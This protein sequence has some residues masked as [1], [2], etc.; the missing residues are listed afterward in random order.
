[1]GLLVNNRVVKIVGRGIQI[2]VFVFSIFFLPYPSFSGI[3]QFFYDRNDFTAKE[4]PGS[5]FYAPRYSAIVRSAVSAKERYGYYTTNELR[6]CQQYLPINEPPLS[7]YCRLTG[8][9]AGE[10]CINYKSKIYCIGGI[11]H[12]GFSSNILEY[13]FSKKSLT[14]KTLSCSKD[15]EPTERKIADTSCVLFSDK[16]YCFGGVYILG[17]E[18]RYYDEIIEYSP[19]D[20][21][22]LVKNSK[23]P[24]Q[25]AGLSCSS[26]DNGKI[27]CIGGNFYEIE[28]MSE[29]L[30]YDPFSDNISVKGAKLPSGRDFASCVPLSG[31]IYCIG[32]RGKD[33]Y[34]SDIL[35]YDYRSDSISKKGDYPYKVWGH[36]CSVQNNKILCFGGFSSV[37]CDFSKDKILCKRS[38]EENLSPVVEF[39]IYSTS[40][41]AVTSYVVEYPPIKQKKSNILPRVKLSCTPYESDIFCFGG[42]I[43]YRDGNL[44][45][46]IFI[47]SANT[48]TYTPKYSH[49]LLPANRVGASCVYYNGGVYCFGGYSST[50]AFFGEL[51]EFTSEVLRYDIITGEISTSPLVCS[52]V[53]RKMADS[54]CVVAEGK[55]YCFSGKIFD[56]VKNDVDSTSQIIEYSPETGNCVIKSKPGAQ[57]SGESCVYP[58]NGTI[59]CFGGSYGQDYF[60]EIYSYELTTEKFAPMKSKFPTGRDFL[61]CVPLSGKIYCIGGRSSSGS[62]REVWEYDYNK[63]V[64]TMLTDY[65][66]DVWGHSCVALN[67]KIYCYGGYT[68]VY[69]YGNPELLRE[70]SNEN[71]TFVKKI[72]IYP[73]RARLSCTSY[74]NNYMFCLGGVTPNIYADDIFQYRVSED[75]MIPETGIPLDA[76]HAEVRIYKGKLSDFSDNIA[77]FFNEFVFTKSRYFD[78]QRTSFLSMFPHST[79][80]SDISDRIVQVFVEPVSFEI[81][82]ALERVYPNGYSIGYISIFTRVSMS[83]RGKTFFPPNPIEIEV[84]VPIGIHYASWLPPVFPWG[85]YNLYIG[86]FLIFFDPVKTEVIIDNND[87]EYLYEIFS[88]P[89]NDE[90]V[91]IE[92]E[93]ELVA[94]YS[95]LSYLKEYEFLPITLPLGSSD[96][97]NYRMWVKNATEVN[98]YGGSGYFSFNLVSI[99]AT[100]YWGDTSIPT[101][102]SI[103]LGPPIYTN[104]RDVRIRI[105]IFDNF[106]GNYSGTYGDRSLSV[107]WKLDNLPWSV[108]SEAP[109]G[110]TEIVINNIPDGEHTV[111]FRGLDISGNITPQE[112]VQSYSF[113]VDTMPPSVSLQID[114]TLSSGSVSVNLSANDDISPQENLYIVWSLDGVRDGVV[115]GPSTLEFDNLE[116]G[117]HNLYVY[118]Y[119]IA[120]NTSEVK[121]DMFYVDRGRPSIFL[122]DKPNALSSL[123]SVVFR[124]GYE[125]DFSTSGKIHW[126]FDGGEWSV[127]DTETAAKK[128]IIISDLSEGEHI[129][130]FRAEDTVGNRGDVLSYSFRSDFTPPHIQLGYYP[131][132]VTVELPLHFGFIIGDDITPP[133]RLRVNWWVDG[134]FSLGDITL[135]GSNVNIMVDKLKDGK[136]YVAALVIDEAGNVSNSVEITVYLD[137]TLRRTGRGGERGGGGCSV[138]N[139]E[140][141][142]NYL[143]LLFVIVFLKSV[144][145]GKQ[146]V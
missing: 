64:T 33:D 32:G 124:V 4:G 138:S 48:N 71:S 110:E 132:D 91:N 20:D 100:G 93:I 58:G 47:Y 131:G 106:H 85:I 125:D 8:G 19:K 15:G 49:N 137:T 27:Y 60:K 14:P 68:S 61:S 95:M 145:K 65:P 69:Q 87:R 22:C 2:F 56:R 126:R 5:G 134:A 135:T 18:V 101:I 50:Y 28:M 63:D 83:E 119:D 53:E 44:A 77:Q 62:L 51:K 70:F 109:N 41:Y 122:V 59:Y 105:G 23:L 96:N 129:A 11:G 54:S 118:A 111:Y 90:L 98:L 127:L 66:V 76:E 123:K 133:E 72:S 67:N 12:S 9:V 112:K 92:K 88:K 57:Y 25:L 108:F 139:I 24:K 37:S 79:K 99:D 7:L 43:P 89:D 103:I 34:Y 142:L 113:T 86:H 75:V 120:G 31:K 55:I 1:M 40:P 6:F 74:L 140:S 26:A 81:E 144:R 13:D 38:E 36:S 16:I 52:G 46:A 107:S 78:I 45:N 97:S 121:T 114:P 3:V 84:R 21:K 94:R 82:Y 102:S 29:I 17:T 141:S 80:L 136:H 128:G 130:E 42:Y 104:K 39:Y 10:N 143:L 115:K 116:E 117:Y 146:R 30:E 73:P 35:E